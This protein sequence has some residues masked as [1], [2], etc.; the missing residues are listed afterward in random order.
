MD[1]SWITIGLELTSLKAWR[2]FDGL[3]LKILGDGP[4]RQE[5]TD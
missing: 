2:E 4:L 3:K 5:L 1:Y